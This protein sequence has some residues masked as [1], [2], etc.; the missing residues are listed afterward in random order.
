MD[1]LLIGTDCGSPSQ[2]E[3][4][5]TSPNSSV[6]TIY[7]TERCHSQHIAAEGLDWRDSTN[8][9]RKPRCVRSIIK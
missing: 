5:I 7:I 6:D 2:S 4:N 9:H 8:S 1:F 3:E